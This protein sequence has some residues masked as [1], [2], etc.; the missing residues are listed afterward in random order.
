M[1]VKLRPSVIIISTGLVVALIYAVVKGDAAMVSGL[2]IA[3]T[4]SLSKLVESEEVSGK[5][6]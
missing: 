1:K 2:A 4:G 5:G 6:T 3:L